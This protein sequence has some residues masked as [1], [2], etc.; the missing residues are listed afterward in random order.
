MMSNQLRKK[1]DVNKEDVM[2]ESGNLRW[3]SKV[4]T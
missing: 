3:E 1:M 2:K 4:G